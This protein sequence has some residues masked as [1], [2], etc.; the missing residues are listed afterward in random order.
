MAAG[1][2]AAKEPVEGGQ[3]DSLDP[4]VPSS[5]N[6]CVGVACICGGNAAGELYNTKQFDGLHNEARVSRGAGSRRRA[7]AEKRVVS[8]KH[9]LLFHMMAMQLWRLAGIILVAPKAVQ[10]ILF[11]WAAIVELSS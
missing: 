6:V 8:R 7:N 2:N 4:L 5:P 3:M 10:C 9:S 1:G 11:A